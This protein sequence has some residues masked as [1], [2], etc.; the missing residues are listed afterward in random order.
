MVQILTVVLT[1]GLRAVEVARQE[2][3][4]EGVH[5]AGVVLNIQWRHREPAPPASSKTPEALW[6]K[7]APLADC[8]RDDSLRR[9]I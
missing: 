8:T 4:R 1:D 3:L 6:L 5:S 9:A 7:H 2:A